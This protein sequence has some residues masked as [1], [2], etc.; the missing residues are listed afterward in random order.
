MS[1]YMRVH[2]I[3]SYLYFTFAGSYFEKGHKKPEILQGSAINQRV[4]PKVFTQSNS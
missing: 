4:F 1:N 3:I 2:Q